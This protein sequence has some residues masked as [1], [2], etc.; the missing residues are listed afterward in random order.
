MERRQTADQSA[1]LTQIAA[2]TPLASGRSVWILA[3]EFVENVQ[4]VQSAIIILYV[5]AHLDIME[6]LLEDVLLY[7]PV[8]S[9]PTFDKNKWLNLGAYFH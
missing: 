3:Q 9:L 7:H 2:L 1:P 4:S 6:I 5:H 8:S